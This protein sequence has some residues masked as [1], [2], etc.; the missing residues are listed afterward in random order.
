MSDDIERA[1]DEILTGVNALLA[2][3]PAVTAGVIAGPQDRG[4]SE[5]FPWHPSV[6]ALLAMVEAQHEQP[7]AALARR[8]AVRWV[9]DRA[10]PL[11]SLLPSQPNLRVSPML[12][13][14]FQT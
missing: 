11:G 5:T 3:A 8:M 9:Q 1:L 2:E 6:P 14:R 13:Q 7:A 12:P 4:T 10:V